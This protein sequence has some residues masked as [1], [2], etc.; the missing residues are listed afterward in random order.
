MRAVNEEINSM[1]EAF[2]PRTWGHVLTL[3][4]SKAHLKELVR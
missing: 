1:H 2:I 3:R 4:F